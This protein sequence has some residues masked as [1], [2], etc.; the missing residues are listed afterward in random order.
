MTSTDFDLLINL[1]GHKIAKKETGLRKPIS[2]QEK[3]TVA[4]RFLATG[5]SFKTVILLIFK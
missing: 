1:I 4:L 3:L 5:E 2:V